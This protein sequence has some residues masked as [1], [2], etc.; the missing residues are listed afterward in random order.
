[1]GERLETQN[2]HFRRP[3]S[4]VLQ[5]ALC[6][7]GLA[8][9]AAACSAELEAYREGV[10]AG[11]ERVAEGLAALAN[12]EAAIEDRQARWAAN[13]ERLEAES[14]ARRDAAIAAGLQDLGVMLQGAG[15]P[16]P[17]VVGPSGE[18]PSTAED[19]PRE[20]YEPKKFEPTVLCASSPA[21]V[22]R[23]R[24]DCSKNGT[25]SD[26]AATQQ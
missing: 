8:D 22:G 23:H 26:A 16:P 3:L 21:D 20:K 25:A 11:E 15:A 19:A 9:D 2:R 10:L 5:L 6:A 12:D 24:V 13:R 14:N 17:P 1:G 4:G 18:A 7:A